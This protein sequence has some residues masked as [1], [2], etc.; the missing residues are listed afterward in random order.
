MLHNV[1]VISSHSMSLIKHVWIQE[2]LGIAKAMKIQMTMKWNNKC[3]ATWQWQMQSN[4]TCDK[5]KYPTSSLTNYSWA[6][7]VWFCY[8]ESSTSTFLVWVWF[9][10]KH[11][12]NK[13]VLIFMESKGPVLPQLVLL[14]KK[15]MW[16]IC[17]FMTTVVDD[18]LSS[19][20]HDTQPSGF[21]SMLWGSSRDVSTIRAA[22]RKSIAMVAL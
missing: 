19:D 1:E 10:S 22:G 8:T 7:M 14:L 17:C 9:F 20:A 11:S 12:P 5:N 4:V 13:I 16:P 3:K 21:C 6:K 18:Q 2:V 15:K